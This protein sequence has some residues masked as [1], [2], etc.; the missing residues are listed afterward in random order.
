MVFFFQPRGCEGDSY[1]IYMGKDKVENE[2]LIRW[3]LP[4]DVW[5]VLLLWLTA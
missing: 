1:M 3:G 4:V 2:E 5:C